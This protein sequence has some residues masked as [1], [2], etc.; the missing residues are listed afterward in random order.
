M[1]F[2]LL[3]HS[4]CEINIYGQA[5]EY[6]NSISSLFL[7]FFGIFGLIFIKIGTSSNV[8]DVKNIYTALIINGLC[9]FMYHFNNKLGWGL[10]DR[11]SMILITIPCYTIAVDLLNLSKINKEIFRF[12][13]ITYIT[14]LMTVTGLQQEILFNILFGIFLASLIVFMFILQIQ[15]NYYLIPKKILNKG[16]NGVLSLVCA[17]SFWI[18]TENLCLQ[19][20]FIKYLFG[21][22][23]WH[24]GCAYGGYLITLIPI[25]LYQ[26]DK[27]IKIDYYFNIPYLQIK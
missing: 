17:G 19:Y 1:D 25:F 14:I 18:I 26:K 24:F 2:N 6:I 20:P 5:P 27:F 15:N 9:S 13:I 7:T 23:F 12:I 4:F 16:W 21:H 22:A 10:M 3:D 8:N 11:F